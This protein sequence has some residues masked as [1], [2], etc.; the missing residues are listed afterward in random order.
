MGLKSS[1][2]YV[3]LAEVVKKI[4]EKYQLENVEDSDAEVSMMKCINKF[5]F[6]RLMIEKEELDTII[7]GYKCYLANSKTTTF[8]SKEVYRAIELY[9]EFCSS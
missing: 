6:K 5:A 7:A 2:P 8:D 3:D 4:A 9:R 1:K